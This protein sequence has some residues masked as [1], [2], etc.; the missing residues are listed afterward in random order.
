MEQK[1]KI[2]IFS[3]P[4]LLSFKKKTK[5]KKTYILHYIK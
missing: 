5:Q 1:L 3:E 4:T 2:I